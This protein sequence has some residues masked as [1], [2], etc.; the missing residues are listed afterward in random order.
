MAKKGSKVKGKTESLNVL[1]GGKLNNVLN[2]WS[3][4]VANFKTSKTFYLVLIALGLTL[5]FY[6]KK[7]WFIAAMVNGTP[8][9]NLELQSKINQQFKTQTLNQLIN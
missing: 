9:T 6:F 1:P 3:G 5:L 8:V 4:K 2:S 7:S